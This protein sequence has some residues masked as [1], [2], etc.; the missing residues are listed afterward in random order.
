MHTTLSFTTK[1]TDK[2]CSQNWDLNDN[3]VSSMLFKLQQNWTQSC[4]RAQWVTGAMSPNGPP[5]GDLMSSINTPPP[6]LHPVQSPRPSLQHR[7]YSHLHPLLTFSFMAS[8]PPH[9]ILSAIQAPVIPLTRSPPLTPPDN[10]NTLPPE[11]PIFHAVSHVHPLHLLLRLV[12][13]LVATPSNQRSFKGQRSPVPAISG[14]WT[15]FEHWKGTFTH[16]SNMQ[17]LTPHIKYLLIKGGA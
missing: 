11:P 16:N 4:Y 3:N 12:H 2:F 13:H 10:S 6:T 1:L 5:S 14:H 7:M 9:V 15:D 17:R 8:T